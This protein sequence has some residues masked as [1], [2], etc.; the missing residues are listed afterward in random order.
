MNISSPT[1]ELVFD[2]ESTP[3]TL[4]QSRESPVSLHVLTSWRLALGLKTENMVT[5]IKAAHCVKAI[6]PSQQS[7]TSCDATTCTVCKRWQ[8]SKGVRTVKVV[9]VAP[10]PVSKS[11]WEIYSF[12]VKPLCSSSRSHFGS[13]LHLAVHLNDYIVLSPQF[14]LRSHLKRKRGAEDSPCAPV[15]AEDQL[16]DC[17]VVMLFL[18]SMNEYEINEICHEMGR[19]LKHTMPCVKNFSSATILHFGRACGEKPRSLDS[20]PMLTGESSINILNGDAPILSVAGIDLKIVAT[21][22]RLACPSPM[23]QAQMALAVLQQKRYLANN[24]VMGGWENWC[25][26][27][28]TAGEW[29]IL[30]EKCSC[31]NHVVCSPTSPVISPAIS[32]VS[33]PAPSPPRS[34]RVRVGV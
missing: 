18:V 16:S 19:L 15:D 17:I 28:L 31:F 33:S 34:K 5:A 11:E 4:R 26:R 13:D 2:N 29:S 27:D 1:A 12:V 25:S 3:Y 6:P 32:P 10:E 22:V 23:A 24:P 20:L 8:A 9:K 7:Y 21:S 30:D 14:V